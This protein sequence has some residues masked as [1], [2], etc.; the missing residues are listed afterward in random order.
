M[1]PWF[2][3]CLLSK[4]YASFL[5]CSISQ[6]EFSGSY[7]IW[8]VCVNCKIWQT[9]TVPNICLSMEAS[10]E[11]LCSLS[12]VFLKKKLFGHRTHIYTA[13]Q[14]DIGTY[15]FKKNKKGERSSICVCASKEPQQNA[16]R[17]VNVHLWNSF[18]LE[19]KGTQFIFKTKHIFRNS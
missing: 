8:K 5:M 12:R 19:D 16:K 9:T 7:F 6:I 3:I 13:S 4:V 15:W 2:L 1:S 10:T 14:Q 11:I 18:C 17:K